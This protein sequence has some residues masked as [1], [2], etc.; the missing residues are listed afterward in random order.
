MQSTWH[1]NSRAVVI[2]LEMVRLAMHPPPP[3][4]FLDS[5]IASESI[6]SAQN[7]ASWRPDDSFTIDIIDSPLARTLRVLGI[8]KTASQLRRNNKEGY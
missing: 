5:E 7:N 2:R 1:R 3:R 8:W 6:F 4:N